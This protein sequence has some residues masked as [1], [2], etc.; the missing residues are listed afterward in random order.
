[1]ISAGVDIG[2]RTIKLAII[3]D[4][5]LIRI[6]TRE[7]SFDA[8]AVCREM[9]QNIK[10]DAITATGYGRH[11]F[12]SHFKCNVIS[13]IKAFSLGAKAIVPS[14]KTILDIGGQDIKAISLDDHG[15]VRKFEMNDKC[16]AGIGTG[17]D[18]RIN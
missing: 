9:L 1:M 4:G 6:L 15:E 17:K 10:Y 16:S 3:N 18:Y 8:M 13:E 2:S 7:N 12:A 14:C 11:L 5:Q